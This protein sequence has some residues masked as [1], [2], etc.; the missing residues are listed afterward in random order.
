MGSVVDPNYLLTQIDRGPQYWR[1]L[2]WTTPATSEAPNG[3]HYSNIQR[4]LDPGL[5]NGP[6]RNAITD[7]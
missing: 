5:V 7:A 3:T 6:G 2:D 1:A 4:Y